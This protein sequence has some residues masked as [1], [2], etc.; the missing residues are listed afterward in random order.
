MRRKT[1]ARGFSLKIWRAETLGVIRGEVTT[2]L[3]NTAVGVAGA[4]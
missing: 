2:A 1:Q 3:F 4:A